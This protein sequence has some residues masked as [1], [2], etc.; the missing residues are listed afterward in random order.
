MNAPQ[1]AALTIPTSFAGRLRAHRE[2]A[3]LSQAE[4][5][6]MIGVSQTAIGQWE[7]STTVPRGRNVNAL[8]VALGVCADEL[9]GHLPTPQQEHQGYAV[10]VPDFAAR[11][12]GAR[13]FARLSLAEVG[14]LVGVSPQAVHKWEIGEFAPSPKNAIAVMKALDIVLPSQAAPALSNCAASELLMAELIIVTM[15]GALTAEQKTAVAAQ[16]EA[17]GVAGVDM[18]RS[19]ERR[20]AIVA[21]GAA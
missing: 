11:L 16:L 18:I 13:A 14:D 1:Q 12:R 21:G 20:A 3:G 8:A 5:A 2:R 15:M 6:A 7:R 10:I 19:Q 9:H 4:L 17:A